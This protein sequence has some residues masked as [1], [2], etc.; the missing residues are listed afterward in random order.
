METWQTQAKWV[1]FRLAPRQLSIR[2]AAVGLGGQERGCWSILSEEDF[3][4]VAYSHHGLSAG[5]LHVRWL[6]S[7]K[8]PFWINRSDFPG[9]S[10][11]EPTR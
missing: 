8:H 9:R 3:Q 4:F 2:S 11:G 5:G 6:Q 1:A 10:P 7:A